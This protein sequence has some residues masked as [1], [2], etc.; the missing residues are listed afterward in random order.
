M[1]EH[2]IRTS[3]RI[4]GSTLPPSAL[5]LASYANANEKQKEMIDHMTQQERDTYWS[6]AIPGTDKVGRIPRQ[7]FLFP[8]L[9]SDKACLFP[10]YR[11][12]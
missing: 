7:V 3:A 12:P 9:R 11:I 6:Y 2:P 4:A 10:L 1:K 5:A 8:L